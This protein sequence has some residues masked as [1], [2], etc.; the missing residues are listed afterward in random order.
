VANAGHDTRSIQ[1]YLGH[2]NIQKGTRYTAL[3]P[4]RAGLKSRLGDRLGTR[5]NILASSYGKIA[6]TIC[7]YRSPWQHLP[8]AKNGISTTN[9]DDPDNKSDAHALSPALS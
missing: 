7:H 8:N 3:A 1:A 6:R 4:N 5:R 2:R 9:M